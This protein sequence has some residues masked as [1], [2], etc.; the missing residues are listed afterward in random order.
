[1]LLAIIS[2]DSHRIWPFFFFFYLNPNLMKH[3][4]KVVSCVIG[5]TDYTKKGSM[6]SALIIAFYLKIN[7]IW[8]K[9]IRFTNF[10]TEKKNYV[11][12]HIWLEKM[13][14]KNQNY[15]CFYMQKRVFFSQRLFLAHKNVPWKVKRKI[16]SNFSL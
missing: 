12:L 8:A 4:I 6:S 10:E 2:D 9:I 3:L 15:F 11:K 16:Y 1:M 5:K 14:W 7:I 13:L